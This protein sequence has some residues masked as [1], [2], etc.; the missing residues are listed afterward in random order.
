MDLGLGFRLADVFIDMAAM[1]TP[2][3]MEI[4]RGADGGLLELPERAGLSLMIG[5]QIP[6]D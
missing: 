3:I 5:C 2:R 4:E 1:F 6:L